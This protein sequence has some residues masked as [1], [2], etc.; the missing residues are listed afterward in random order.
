MEKININ[1]NIVIVLKSLFLTI[2]ALFALEL[3]LSLMRSIGLNILNDSLLGNVLLEL[4]ILIVQ[5]LIIRRHHTGNLLNSLGLNLNKDSS[6]YLF[7][8]ILIGLVGT[9]LIYLSI[10]LM[11]IGFY[12]GFGFKFYNFA[13]VISFIASMFIRAFFAGICEE[14]FF[15]GVL[16]SYLSKYKGKAFGLLISSLVF[17]VFH[18]TRYNNLYQLSS[19]LL[20]GITLG[21]IYIKTKSLYMSIGLHFATD[22]FMNLVNLR[23]QPSLLVF[24]INSKY[25][26]DYLTQISFIL[27]SIAYISLLLILFLMNKINS[28]DLKIDNTL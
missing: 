7:K 11:K 28:K 19:V 4:T 14:V 3:I 21:Y 18:C 17:A 25:S 9:I 22:F 16:L 8:G 15:R 20:C 23:N 27:M 6:K 10:F 13:I 24:D 12:E 5:I 2:I 1:E 26:L